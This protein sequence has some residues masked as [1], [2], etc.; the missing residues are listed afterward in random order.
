MDRP[1]L[2]AGY[3]IGPYILKDIVDKKM[4]YRRY[5]ISGLGKI[6][7]TPATSVIEK[8]LNDKSEKLYYRGDAYE[9]LVKFDTKESNEIIKNFRFQ[10]NDSLDKDVVKYVDHISY[11][12][13][14]D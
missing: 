11:L 13:Q 10:A 9:T 6:K 8:I 3:I 5:A 12:K 14:S 4:E 7:Y 2:D 1:I